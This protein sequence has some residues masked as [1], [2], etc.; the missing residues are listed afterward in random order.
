MA[1][2]YDLLGQQRPGTNSV[3]VYAVECGEVP[4][5]ADGLH[6]RVLKFFTDREAFQRVQ[7]LHSEPAAAYCTTVVKNIFPGDPQNAQLAVY[8][9]PAPPCIVTMRL[10][11]FEQKTSCKDLSTTQMVS[12]LAGSHMMSFSCI[13]CESRTPYRSV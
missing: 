6:D 3:T 2:R 4:Q 5:G 7:M 1:C 13:V 8:H 11:T 9:S 10:E 12:Y